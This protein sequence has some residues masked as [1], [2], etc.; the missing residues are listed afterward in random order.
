MQA[1][2]TIKK[3]FNVKTM[4][5]V[6]L[7]GAISFVLMYLEIP[8]WF[9][10]GFYKID[11]SEVSV[12]I[13]AFALGPIPGVA[14]E[15]IKVI[16]HLI[17]KG[18]T[19]AGVGDFANFLIGCAYIVP[20]AIVYRRHKTMKG[21]LIGM[22][23]GTVCMTVLGSLLNAFVLLPVYATAFGMPL[24]KIVEMGTVINPAIDNLGTFVLFAVVPFNLLKCILDSIFTVLLYKKVSGILHK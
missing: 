20:A 6:G 16:L 18:T 17:L 4:A 22:G 23:L 3:T 19:T 2:T 13:G 24:E 7:L 1:N 5:K 12:L 15:L 10:P 14:I 9:A 8:L 21:A 11:F